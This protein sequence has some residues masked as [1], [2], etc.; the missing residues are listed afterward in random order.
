MA[1][2]LYHIGALY[3]QEACLRQ[4]GLE[5]DAKLIYWAQY[6]KLLV[7]AFFAWLPQTL[8]IQVPLPSNPF[9]QAARYALAREQV[10]YF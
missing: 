1:Q 4:R 2:T 6:A 8:A 5:A 7:D 10:F 3:E 9:T